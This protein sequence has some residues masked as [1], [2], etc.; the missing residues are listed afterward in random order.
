MPHGVMVE[1]QGIVALG[2]EPTKDVS[3][4]ML[5]MPKMQQLPMGPALIL[6]QK[7]LM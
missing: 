2:S 6:V 7:M 1:E 3:I 5:F 4:T